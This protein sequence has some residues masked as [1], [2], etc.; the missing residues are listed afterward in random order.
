[1]VIFTG[2]YWVIIGIS[3]RRRSEGKVNVENSRFF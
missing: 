1:M 2:D 3:V